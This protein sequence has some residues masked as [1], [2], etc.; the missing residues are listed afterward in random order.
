M[1][2]IF[3]YAIIIIIIIY[4]WYYDVYIII[5]KILFNVDSKAI[6][7]FFLRTQIQMNIIDHKPNLFKKHQ[8]FNKFINNK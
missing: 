6:I 1:R 3:H 8:K 7:F 5:Y 2:F 4:V